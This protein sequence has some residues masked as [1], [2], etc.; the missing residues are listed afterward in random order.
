MNA[1]FRQSVYLLA[2]SAF[3]C[4]EDPGSTRRD[5]GQDSART[6]GAMSPSDGQSSGDAA[7]GSLDLV[8]IELVP[9][10]S[11]LVVGNARPRTVS[12]VVQGTRRDGS[13]MS[14]VTGATWTLDSTRIGTV[15]GAG[16]F[17]ANAEISGTVSVR[18]EVTGVDGPL[19]AMATLTVRIS[20]T[21]TDGAIDPGLLAEIDGMPSGTATAPVLSYPLDQAVMPQNVRAPEVH[22]QPSGVVNDVFR[23]QL[24][25]PS[26]SVTAYV[27]ARAAGFGHRWAVNDASWRALLDS[28]LASPITIRVDRLD[29]ATR[30]FTAASSVQVQIARG[31]VAGTIYYW[32]VDRG[33]IMKISPASGRAVELTPRWS[34]AG[35]THCIACHSVSRNGRYLA[36]SVENDLLG[37]VLDLTSAETPPSF[38]RSESRRYSF[39]TFNPDATRMLVN[40]I[41]PPPAG[42][43]VWTDP[44]RFAL[45]D[46]TTG[47]Q[48]VASGLPN[49][50]VSQPEWSPDGMHVAMITNVSSTF[51]RADAYQS[52]DLGVMAAMPGDQFGPVQVL[53]TGASLAGA[54]EGG[55]SDAHPSWTPNSRAIAFAHGEF[56]RA[57][58]GGGGGATMEYPGALYL[59]NRAGGA[60]TR[61]DRANN[62]PS[63]NRAYWPTFSPFE[64]ASA[65]G[66]ARYYWLAYFASRPYGNTTQRRQLWVTAVDT[67]PRAA[68][69]PSHVPYW[70]PGQDVSTDN[71]AAYWT[72][73]SCRTNGNTCTSASE[74]CSGRCMSPGAGQPSVC[75]PPPPDACRGEGATCGAGGDCC[76]GLTCVGNV[77][78]AVPG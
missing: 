10:M 41:T 16:I 77:C 34:A 59:V 17:T 27:L 44:R 39:S 60:A 20:N 31:A 72:A 7:M 6:D 23:V 30:R 14:R 32:N 33:R 2:A 11:E 71:A 28:D 53:H 73:E 58:S 63:G 66:T 19:R 56:G 9:G 74:C 3:A 76:R 70:L 22:W 18:A 40:W 64:S 49:T 4:G 26:V 1:V 43:A 62:G 68:S 25:K 15:D 35:E 48:L 42:S 57:T 78:L 52:G 12:Y 75:V 47:S 54:T 29:S 21:H 5:A 38:S 45:L 46:P 37:A 51:N 50:D 69:D 8:R 65:D 61:L 24:S 36:V 55:S 67:M 13:T